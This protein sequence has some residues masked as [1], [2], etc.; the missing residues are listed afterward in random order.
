LGWRIITKGWIIVTFFYQLTVLGSLIPGMGF[1]SAL[2][3]IVLPNGKCFHFHSSSI[4][5][6][7]A[8]RVAARLYII[9]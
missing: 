5:Q 1:A 7:A 2:N 3:E 4:A 8:Y 9:P 6:V